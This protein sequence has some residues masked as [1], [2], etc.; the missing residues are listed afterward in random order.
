MMTHAAGVQASPESAGPCASSGEPG[1][2]KKLGARIQAALSGRTGTESV[3]VYDRKRGIRCAVADGGRY[4]SASVVKATILG[5]LLRQAADEGRPLTAS[6]K[7][8]ATKMIARSDNGAAS[9]LWRSVGR[10]R[11]GRFL[12]GA[13]MTQTTLGPSG[14]WGL[15]QITARDQLRLLGRFTASNT[16]LSDEARA[17]AL[18]LMNGVVASQRWGTPAGRPAGVTWHVKNGWLPRQGRSWRVHS[19]GAFDG[20]GADY[21][22]VVLTRDTPSM[23]YGVETIERVARAVHRDLN[24][25]MRPT[26][27]ESTPS[28]AWEMSDGSVPPG[29]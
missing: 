28:D 15:T 1:I 12:A 29:R 13:D 11:L 23:A 24:P 17:Y 9:A 22:I 26:A 27:P 4:D 20:G 19:I 8:L 21:M 6:E 10:A 2:A 14:Y 5:A 25:G 3:A 16:L 18:R 7:S